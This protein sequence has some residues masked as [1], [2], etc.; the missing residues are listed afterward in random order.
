M[1]ILLTALLLISSQA[2]AIGLPNG[3]R[4]MELSEFKDTTDYISRSPE[5]SYLSAYADF[6]GDSKEDAVRFLT[7]DEKKEHGIFISYSDG[8][9][10]KHKK[11]QEVSF[12]EIA[13]M[14]VS[15]ETHQYIPC[16][17]YIECSKLEPKKIARNLPAIDLFTFDSAG[18]IIYWDKKKQDFLQIWTSD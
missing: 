18:S 10:I 12:R 16:E 4:E 15:L 1:R 8:E 13:R 9:N 6:N 11:I 5:K 2:Q 17:G 14:G 7:H 3:W